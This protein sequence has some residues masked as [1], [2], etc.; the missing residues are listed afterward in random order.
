MG[1]EFGLKD[2]GRDASGAY[3]V[4]QILNGA[5]ARIDLNKFKGDNAGFQAIT[6]KMAKIQ[7]AL[8][9][10]QV[11]SATTFI[12]DLWRMYST[13]ERDNAAA[14]R[15]S[16]TAAPKVDTTKYKKLPKY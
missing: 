6:D 12:E 3:S 16:S 10:G 9:A 5:L 7:S 2:S 11:Q 4:S 14:A 13:R 8:D 15:P 1:K